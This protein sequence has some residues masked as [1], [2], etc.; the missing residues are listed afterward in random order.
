MNSPLRDPIRNI[1]F[2]AAA[3]DLESSII[4]GRVVMRHSHASLLI[5]QGFSPLVIKERLGHE[6]IQTT[7]NTYSHLYPSKQEE[8]AGRLQDL[9]TGKQKKKLRRFFLRKIHKRK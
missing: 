3:E 7:L 6:D 5:E 4:D 1:V 9:A 8:I 2:S